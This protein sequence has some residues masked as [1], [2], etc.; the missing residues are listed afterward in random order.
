M[1]ATL[2]E[3]LAELEALQAQ[4]DAAGPP[5]PPP[6]GSPQRP[7]F[8]PPPG[9]KPKKPATPAPKAPEKPST[10]IVGSVVDAAKNFGK[11]VQ[12]GNPLT[13]QGRKTIGDRTMGAAV[14]IVRGAP[15][16]LGGTLDTFADAGKL[17][18]DNM[19]ATYA[20]APKGPLRDFAEASAL[21]GQIADPA[22]LLETAR[23]LTVGG[24]S[25]KDVLSLRQSAG[26]VGS[27]QTNQFFADFSA[28][29]ALFAAGGL[30]AKGAQGVLAKA[31]QVA[32]N[33]ATQAAIAGATAETQG[34][35]AKARQQ[36]RLVTAAVAGGANLVAEP[37]LG[38][39]GS[40]IKGKPK[41]R[42]QTATA[43]EGLQ[44]G[45]DRTFATGRTQEARYQ[46][47]DKV[48]EANNAPE[49][50]GATGQGPAVSDG[51]SAVSADPV[52]TVGGETGPSAPEQLAQ[53]ERRG[54][55]PVTA[56]DAIGVNPEG[57]V[58]PDYSDAN[59]ALKTAGLPADLA[60]EVNPL[61]KDGRIAVAPEI[62]QAADEAG[63]GRFL[64][65]DNEA[66][67]AT[68][69]FKAVDD[70]GGQRVVGSMT[71]ADLDNF[72]Q[73]VELNREDP[74]F[75]PDQLPE[76][77]TGQWKLANV[78]APYDVGPVLAALS[79]Q[80]PARKITSDAELMAAVKKQADAIG[81]DVNDMLA[82]A[83]SNSKDVDSVPVVAGVYRTLHARAASSI[84]ALLD[85]L[86]GDIHDLA[87]DAVEVQDLIRAIHPMVNL[88]QAFAEFKSE[89]GSTLR[90][91]GLPDADTYFANF[92]KVPE[93]HIKPTD[94]LDGLPVLPRTKTELDQWVSAWGVTKG[95]PAARAKFLEGLTFMRGKWWTLRNSFANFF[96][97]A[98]VSGPA[99][100]LR[101]LVGPTFVSGIQALER[102]S[103]SAALAINPFVAAEV[104]QEA[105]VAMQTT[106]RAYFEA[107]GSFQ[108]AATAAIKALQAGHTVLD[109]GAG[110]LYN[111][112]S[113]PIPQTLIDATT[114][115]D[116]GWTG[117]I[118]YHLANIVNWFP[119][120]VHR[121]H[122]STQEFAQRV[123]YLGEV[124]ASAYLEGAQ[125]RLTGEDLKAYVTNRVMN[126]TDEVTW[127][128]LDKGAFS[129][130][131][132]TTFVKPVGDD[133]SPIVRS[134]AGS[135]QSMRDS[136]PE[137]RYVLPI[138]SVPANALG[139]TVRRVP[140]VGSLFRESAEE[141]AGKH[142][143]VRQAEAY[144]RFMASSAF[145][146]IGMGLARSGRLT[147][148][149]PSDPKDRKVWELQGR[150]PYSLRVGGSDAEG[151]YWVNY[152]KFD[153]IGPLLALP[154]LVSD[155]S[156]HTQG[157]QQAMVLT[158]IS[159]LAQYTKDQAAL[160]GLSQIMGLG[161]DANKDKGIL[162]RFAEQ[163]VSGF[164]PNFITQ[165]GRNNFDPL[166]REVNNPLEAIM[167]KL[168]GTSTLLD[169]QRNLFGEPTEKVQNVGLNVFPLSITTANT[170]DKDPAID[171]LDR[172]VQVTGYVPG[173]KAPTLPGGTTDMR[174]VKL[175]DGRSLYDAIM[176]YRTDTL[177]DEGQTL[178]ESITALI[179]S[180]EYAAAVDADGGQTETTY[181]DASR[182]KLLQ[183][184]FQR[185]DK[186][187]VQAV[188]NDSPTAARWLA[189]GDVK[190]LNDAALRDVPDEAVAADPSGLLTPLGIDINDFEEKVKGQ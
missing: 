72:R 162:E 86:P 94:P 24:Q 79:D 78:G 2:Q 28:N 61:R 116:R 110:E 140:V 10:G 31:T 189:A 60:P 144:G 117:G 41:V 165:L 12:E 122:G 132:R 17:R 157:D 42:V 158:A 169:P 51:D 181:G 104:R 176:R 160:T 172:F 85:A 102:T 71:K 22:Q 21:G 185:Y 50:V 38:L 147:G 80:I 49:N 186:L 74:F 114:A 19:Q 174:E 35:T 14:G 184:V 112:R 96:T 1:G 131:Q 135:V 106:P 138:F 134:I 56:E 159:A 163:T 33:S 93:G 136:V 90:A 34:K 76:A 109:D 62:K 108:D 20:R 182:G 66:D 68:V 55:M 75:T 5:P 151:G 70:Q 149:G 133:N 25:L 150:Q 13:P 9:A 180:D 154:A 73:Q 170:W 175:E 27:P 81:F 40:A 18:G 84:D 37:L 167:N 54:D 171:E 98:I 39:V 128:A 44:E 45:V 129:K 15:T 168:P 101:N 3:T 178:R 155:K 119:Q 82:W 43:E 137:W 152:N 183:E 53:G 95:D 139:E 153:L 148:A 16:L 67:P 64:A 156:V 92:G 47:V 126:S 91:L 63:V 113:Q 97:A 164:V 89:A 30:E 177:D 48:V 111:L 143:A 124:R 188:A 58:P 29:I 87:D 83:T 23:R 120:Q 11:F 32:K 142:G 100:I 4:K 107:I 65:A 187:A 166:K 121:L 46:T 69:L 125:Q 118:P 127:G 103:G 57:P 6:A 52:G 59:A 141:L 36:D 146:A 161:E 115:A 7:A 145:L 123:A 99:T 130:S 179:Q 8:L 88:H 190:R 105:R 26:K 173:L 77:P